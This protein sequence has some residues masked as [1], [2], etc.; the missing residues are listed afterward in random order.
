MTMPER[1]SEYFEQIAPRWD[2][3]RSGYF[4]EEVRKKAIEMAYLQ[5]EMIVADIGGGT[6]YMTAG[7]VDLVQTIHLVD[8][9][10]A[11]LDEAKR[12]LRGVCKR[13]ISSGGWVGAAIPGWNPGC[14]FR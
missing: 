11:M 12:N 10:S 1:T 7:L 6:G 13:G 9:S 14:S 5:P 2:Q 8:G 3:I 4:S